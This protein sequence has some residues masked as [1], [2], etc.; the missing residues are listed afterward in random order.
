MLATPPRLLEIVVIS[1]VHLGTYG[2]QAKALLSYLKSIKPKQLILN[3]D[4]VDI[5]QFSKR[6][7]PKSHTQV[8]QHLLKWLAEGV[9]IIYLPGNHDEI[10]RRFVGTAIGGI[11]IENKCLLQNENGATAWVFHGDVF[12][13]VMQHS[14]WLAKLGGIGYDLLILINQFVNFFSEKIFKVGRISLSKKVKNQVKSAV[15][16]IHNFENT[17]AEIGISKGY[18]FVICGHIHKPEIK[19]ITTEKGTIMYLNSGDW[20]EHCTA[21]EFNGTFWELYQHTFNNDAAVE[22]DTQ[23]Y[24]TT[25]LFEEMLKEFSLKA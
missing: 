7:W 9:E 15:K 12:D 8:I 4:I 1:D 14:R 13:V 23:L 18:G 17:A 22:I 16:F 21:L 19:T 3:G 20:V 25:A 6:Y 11:K 5:W 24:K 2:C 10:M